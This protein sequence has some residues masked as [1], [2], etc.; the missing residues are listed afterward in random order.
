MKIFIRSQ[1]YRDTPTTK[2]EMFDLTSLKLGKMKIVGEFESKAEPE[3]WKVFETVES[4]ENYL[5]VINS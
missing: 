4:A 1:M 3:Y 2:T 5:K